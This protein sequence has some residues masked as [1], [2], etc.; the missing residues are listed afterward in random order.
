[1]FARTVTKNILVVNSKIMC[2]F[3][4]RF[5][6]G[7]LLTGFSH[8]HTNFSANFSF[9]IHFDSSIRHINALRK[10]RTQQI[11]I[12]Q[13][14]FTM[15]ENKVKKTVN[16]RVLEVA[17]VDFVDAE[18]L[19]LEDP[20]LYTLRDDNNRCV[21]HWAALMGKERLVE[22]LLL[23]KDCE[24]D[25]EDDSG[26]SALILAT[27]KGALSICVHLLDHGA[28]VNHQNKNGHN[29]TKYAGSK[30]HQQV[31]E[32]LLNRGGDVNARDNVGE[33]PL[34]RVASTENAECLRL[35]LA[36]ATMSVQLD[37]QNSE[38][39]TALHL[40]CESPNASCALLLIDHGASADV[41]N[42]AEQTPLDVC[43]PPLRK[44]LLAKLETVKSS[45]DQPIYFFIETILRIEE[46]KWSQ[47]VD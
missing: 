17:S 18:N 8:Y 42:K 19:L 20:S 24:V 33:T 28:N 44:V 21:L 10:L 26:A 22:H 35:I 14:N 38:G 1:M 15:A 37:M 23:H 43:K 40:A 25:A 32:L 47:F 9:V 30:N 39:N 5:R 11:C 12:Y 4:L 3:C 7:V 27:L 45:W 16:D 13:F 6:Y 31:L 29:A 34:H 46:I 2:F 41:L 36:H